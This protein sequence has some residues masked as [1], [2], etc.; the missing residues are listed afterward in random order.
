MKKKDIQ[1]QEWM[2]IPHD[3]SYYGIWITDSEEKTVKNLGDGIW[4][5][6]G[7]GIIFHTRSRAVAAAQLEIASVVSFSPSHYK[8]EVREIK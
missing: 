8:M 6:F 3:P 4:L 5:K 2:E 1:P 7:D